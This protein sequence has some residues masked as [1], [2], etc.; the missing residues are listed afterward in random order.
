MKH[1]D[2]SDDPIGKAIDEFRT[3]IVNHPHF[4]T[5]K[6]LLTHHLNGPTVRPLILVVGGTGSG[7]STLLRVVARS[8]F[9]RY[10]PQMMEDPTFIPVVAHEVKRRYG[11]F[12][13]RQHYMEVLKQLCEP[14]VENKRI[15]L[16]ADERRLLAEHGRK[17]VSSVELYELVVETALRMRGVR[18]CLYDEGQHMYATSSEA[19]QYSRMEAV[20]SE[21]SLSGRRTALFGPASL[22]HASDS[23]GQLW[24]RA[25]VIH[26]ARYRIDVKDHRQKFRKVQSSF[27]E[28]SPL[29][30]APDFYDVDYSMAKTA[31]FVGVGSDWALEANKLAMANGEKMISR[32]ILDACALSNSAILRIDQEARECEAFFEGVSDGILRAEL[33]RP[34]GE[35]FV[36]AKIDKS[37]KARALNVPRSRRPGRRKPSRD[38]VG[39]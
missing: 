4:K 36:K 39:Y 30:L 16:S 20:K 26:L 21:A 27:G 9:E 22:L 38:R 29:P 31:G 6:D 3:K 24:R 17:K 7:K 25:N 28:M 19:S 14:G 15:Y 1:N 33:Q 35:S 37:E 13:W 11:P 18:V 32:E 12:L 23:N 5:A 2:L 8:E 34:R 10:L